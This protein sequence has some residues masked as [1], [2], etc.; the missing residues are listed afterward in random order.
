MGALL[1]SDDQRQ[2][3]SPP[4]GF[5]QLGVEPGFAGVDDDSKTM[6]SQSRGQLDYLAAVLR[7][8]RYRI[9]IQAVGFPRPLL[10]E[11]DRGPVEAN[12]EPHARGGAKSQLGRQ[13]IVASASHER[14]LGAAQAFVPALEHGTCVIVEPAHQGRI[15]GVGDVQGAQAGLDGFKGRRAGGI[16]VIHYPGGVGLEALVG[17]HIAVQHP[18][19]VSLEADLVIRTE[20]REQRSVVVAEQLAVGWPADLVTDAVHLQADPAETELFEPRPGELDRL[21]VEARVV[22]A[23]H[24]DAELMQL[25]EPT[26]LGA[27]VPEIRADVEKP[28]GLRLLG[29]PALKVRPDDGG[30]ALPGL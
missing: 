10:L 1:R 13:A 26:R 12:R 25:P 9:D 28:H 15:Q 22:I 3:G 29:Q 5:A 16:E 30:R 2:P 24:L 20:L 23:D 8:D 21:H 14:V 11:D 4:V 6:P 7:T 17:G 18:Q 27:A 19:R